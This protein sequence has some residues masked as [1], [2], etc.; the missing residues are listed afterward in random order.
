MRKVYIPTWLALTTILVVGIAA[1]A[2]VL[3]TISTINFT[4]AQYQTEQSS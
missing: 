3:H 2:L 1:T 4:Y